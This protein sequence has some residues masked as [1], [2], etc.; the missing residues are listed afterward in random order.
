MLLQKHDIPYEIFEASDRPGGRIFTYSFRPDPDKSLNGK[1]EYY[2]VGAM[3]FPNNNA[4]KATFDLFKELGFRFRNEEN[5]DGELIEFKFGIGD[6][7]RHFNGIS[8]TAKDAA[9]GFDLFGEGKPLGNVPRG[10]VDVQDTDE[11]GNVYRGV[12]ACHFKAF[13]DLRKKLASDF[14]KEWKKLLE[15]WDWASTHSY[16]ARAEELRFP[17]PVID[18]IEKHKSG[19]GRYAQAL[20]EEILTALIVYDPNIAKNGWWCLEGGSEVLIK[21]MLFKLSNPP[22][23][24]H[25]VTA[26]AED[27]MCF[28]DPSR[29]MKVSIQGRKYEYF[30]H[31]VSTVSFA[32]L[33]TVDTDDVF[34]NYGQREA[35]RVL[36]YGDAIKVGIKFKTRWWEKDA[37]KYKQL[38]GASNT[39]RQSRAVVYPSYGLEEEGPGVLLVSYNWGQDATRFGALIKNSDWTKQLDPARVRPQSEEVLLEQ[40]YQD[41]AVMHTPDNFDSEE[42]KKFKE[43]LIEDTLDYHTF[44]WSRSPFTM[45]AFAEFHPGQ[46]STLF[47]DI[48][49]PA[50]VFGNFHFAGELASHHHGWVGGALDSAMRVVEQIVMD[51]GLGLTSDKDRSLVFDSQ[52]SADEWHLWGMVEEVDADQ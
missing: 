18:W 46:F 19:T 37:V 1:H 26:V 21:E 17:Q 38:G 9:A 13:S 35:M 30:S 43:T 40:I 20:T 32:A 45:G 25:R 31:V 49:Q 41:L 4:N 6:N 10:F 22:H 48:L 42:V 29:R 11:E 51:L 15:E 7:I 12:D 16:L 33:R 47:A 52:T 24:N 8:T 14:D 2:D 27:S 28:P 23:Y 39:D 36:Y 3:R 34:M 50:G 44:D 5:P